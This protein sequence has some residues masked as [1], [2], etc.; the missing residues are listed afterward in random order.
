MSNFVSS[1]FFRFIR[2][3]FTMGLIRIKIPI[4]TLGE[5]KD[6]R[7]ENYNKIKTNLIRR[8]EMFSFEMKRNV[9]ILEIDVKYEE[10]RNEDEKILEMIYQCLNLEDS[11]KTEEEKVI[12]MH[13]KQTGNNFMHIKQTDNNF[14]LKNNCSKQ[15]D[16]NFIQNPNVVPKT[17]IKTMEKYIDIFFPLNFLLFKILHLKKLNKILSDHNCKMSLSNSTVKIEGTDRSLLNNCTRIII[18]F[19]YSNILLETTGTFSYP[20][21]D[22]LEI[23]RNN[24]NRI[25]FGSID[26]LIGLE[27]TKK[28][29]LSLIVP[30]ETGYF[31]CGKK[32]GK[33][34]KIDSS[35]LQVLYLNE[36]TIF[37][38]TG[39]FK[40]CIK[41]YSQ[42]FDE[43]PYEICFNIDRKLH[44]KIIGMDGC[45]IQ[46]IM[47]KYNFY[48]KFLNSKESENMG[49]EGNVILR[50]P[51]KNKEIL[52]KAKDEIYSL[53]IGGIDHTVIGEEMTNY[54]KEESINE[55]TVNNDIKDEIFNLEGIGMLIEMCIKK[56]EQQ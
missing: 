1:E 35:I 39:L 5:S 24:K 27:S 37:K 38:M 48:V 49:L 4:A 21:T 47:K 34:F 15:T 41:C 6:E 3:I 7:L 29:N 2:N 36:N 32:M 28:C 11:F 8:I 16:N 22:F 45:I 55:I 25:L 43:F 50:T 40:E 51:R 30:N 33:I 42:L 14:M 19:Y 54:E 52:N 53:S 26:T 9:K 23:V 56:K 17:L 13:S 46:K 18:D 20:E 44:K 12:F 31:I 10:N